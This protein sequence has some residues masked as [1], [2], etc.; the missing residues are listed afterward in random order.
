[1]LH[2]EAIHLVC[3]HAQSEAL[4]RVEDSLTEDSEEHHNI[5]DSEEN[6]MEDLDLMEEQDSVGHLDLILV[7][8]DHTDLMMI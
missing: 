2:K 3:A 1:M 4:K 8:M 7:I 5:V 6:H